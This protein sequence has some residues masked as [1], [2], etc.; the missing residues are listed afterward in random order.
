MLYNNFFVFISRLYETIYCT[1]NQL[2]LVESS[3]YF[4]QM[5]QIFAGKV[6]S[7]SDLRRKLN[8]YLFTTR[9]PRSTNL[10]RI[11]LTTFTLT[12]N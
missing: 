8:Y 4:I 10:K 3:N 9:D 12:E 1:L 5:F 7:M 2:L 6:S 11:T